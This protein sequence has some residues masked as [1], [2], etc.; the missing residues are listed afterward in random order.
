M[1]ASETDLWDGGS[2]WLFCYV[3]II[4]IP[5]IFVCIA[6]Y[7]VLRDRRA[8]SKYDIEAINSTYAKFWSPYYEDDSPPPATRSLGAPRPDMYVPT[9]PENR[10]GPRRPSGFPRLA[11]APTANLG[12]ML[13][14]GSQYQMAGDVSPRSS[15]A[16]PVWTPGDKRPSIPS[17]MSGGRTHSQQAGTHGPWAAQPG[18]DWK[19]MSV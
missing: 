5:I 6:I 13:R 19:N 8:R 4:L 3:V 12:G 10:V 7:S 17:I 1:T 15:P 9:L 18:A 11:L 14:H 2:N 16:V